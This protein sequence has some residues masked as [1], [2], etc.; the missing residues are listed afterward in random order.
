MR[1]AGATAP[2]P[3]R[4][5]GSVDESR[6]AGF[7]ILAATASGVPDALIE[8]DLGKTA[9]PA[10]GTGAHFTKDTVSRTA[11]AARKS[12]QRGNRPTHQESKLHARIGLPQVDMDHCLLSDDR[13]C[14]ICR[15]RCPYEDF[16]QILEEHYT[17][18]P[19]VNHERCPAA[20]P[21]KWPAQPSPS[22]SSSV[23]HNLGSLMYQTP[24]TL[25]VWPVM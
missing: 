23:R 15:N 25:M 10:C 1:H 21:V 4:P 9:L 12:A 17:L 3:L 8:P 5:P 14:A 22:R 11:S 6:F 7:V 20:G 13:E 24:L 16:S 18:E 2:R 19:S